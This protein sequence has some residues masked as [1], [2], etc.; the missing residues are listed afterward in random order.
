MFFKMFLLIKI[1]NKGTPEESPKQQ[2]ANVAG[3]V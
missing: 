3:L 2:I 1:Q